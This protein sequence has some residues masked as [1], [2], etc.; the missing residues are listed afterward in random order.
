[1]IQR[2]STQNALQAALARSR[3]VVL[4]GPRQCGKTTLARELLS[5][6]KRT[7]TP[8]ITPSIRIAL[9]DLGL[10]RVAVIYPGTK[11]FPIAQRVEAVPLGFMASGQPLFI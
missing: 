11:R 8:R 3:I 1:M 7:D 4:S 10:D 5:E 6:C 9:E 2:R